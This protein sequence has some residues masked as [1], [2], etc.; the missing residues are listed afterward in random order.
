VTITA[1]VVVSSPSTATYNK[2]ITVYVTSP[3]MNDTLKYSS[4][5][6]Y[7]YFR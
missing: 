1:N 4:I 7:W 2:R 5:Y 3:Y 6:S